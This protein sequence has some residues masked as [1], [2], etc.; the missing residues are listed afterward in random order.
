MN[1]LVLNSAQSKYPVGNDPWIQA[2]IKTV[3]TLAERCVHLLCSTDPSPWSLVT[4]LAGHMRMN[5]NLIVKYDADEAGYKEFA[6]LKEDFALDENRTFPLFTGV[7]SAAH[8]KKAW[9]IRDQYA[10]RIA[11]SVYPVSIKPGGRLDTLLSKGDFKA[12]I[13]NDFR[14]E[15]TVQKHKNDYDFTRCLINPFPTGNWLVHWTRAS[16][17]PWPGEKSREFYRDLIMHPTIYVR[18]AE[19]TLI[20][21]LTD[22]TI[23]GSSW[24]IPSGESAVSFTSLDP[25]EAVHLMR[26]RKR[27]VRYSF[28]PFG[29]GIKHE[30]LAGKGVK[31]IRYETIQQNTPLTQ[32]LFSHAPGQNGHW[33]KEDEWRIQGELRLDDIERDDMVVIVPDETTAGRISS[34]IGREYSIHVLFKY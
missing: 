24:K 15:W 14:I 13:R 32:R 7:P 1:V 26:W 18:S 33:T 20:K 22:H 3:R 28:E 8:Y 31:K 9:Q 30:V 12:E 25:D 4:Y 19:E 6:H 29:I 27:F 17:G 23:R 11:D 16:Q 2:S 21:I 10:L 5:I 34:R